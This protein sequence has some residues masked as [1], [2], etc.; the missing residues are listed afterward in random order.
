MET[1]RLLEIGQVAVGVFRIPRSGLV[2][3]DHLDGVALALV[4]QIVDRAVR[5]R[6]RAPA[7]AAPFREDRHDQDHDKDENDYG[8]HEAGRIV[9]AHRGSFTTL[10]WAARGGGAVELG[11]GLPSIVSCSISSILVPSGSNRLT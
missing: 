8:P 3:D 6:P 1:L 5:A 2:L 9:R 7:S 10:P 11:A 4:E